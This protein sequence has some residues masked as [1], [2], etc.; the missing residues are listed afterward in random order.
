MGFQLFDQYSIL[1]F[2]VGI[3][4]FFWQFNFWI[5]FGIHFLFE[6]IEN[7][8]FGMKLINNYF[9]GKGMIRWPGGKYYADS[10]K[11]IIGDNISFI[12]GFLLAYVFNYYGIKNN[13][14][15]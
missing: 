5:A 8:Q 10:T 9:V 12:V 4:L 7:T 1:H 13:W 11:N 6:I 2:A 3:I 14:H 15:E